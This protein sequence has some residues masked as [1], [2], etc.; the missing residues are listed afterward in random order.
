LIEFAERASY[1]GVKNRLNNFIQLPLPAGGNGAGA[2]P[3]GTQQNAGALGMGLQTASAITLLLTFL[4]YLTPLFGGYISDKRWGRMKTIWYGVWVGAVSHIILIVAAIPSVIK[5]GHALAPTIISILT[6]AVGSGLI[7]PNLLP[8]L[9]DQYPHKRDAVETR[10][11]GSRV[12]IVREASLERMTMFFYWAV[13]VGSFLSLG[14]SYCAKRI[15]F[16]LAFLIPGI[17]YF[18]MVP[19]L[20]ILAP[21]LKKETP[22]GVSVLAEALKVLKIAFAGNFI[23]RSRH[24][25]FWE[26]PKPSA[27]KVRGEDERLEAVTKKGNKKISWNDQFVEDVK[28]TWDAC[29]I[30]LFFVIYNINDVGIGGIQNSQAASMITNGVPNDLLD[31]FNP[32]TIIVFIPILD[33]IVYPLLRRW[34]INFRPVYRMFLGFILASLGSFAGAIIQWRIYET[35]PCGY[36]ATNC[37]VGTGVS[38][39]SVWF[40]II[41]YV[42][43]ASSECF[44]MT[45]AYEVAYTRAPDHMKGVVMALFLFTQSLSAAI[46]EACTSA[47]VDPYLIWPFVA[48][49]AAGIVSA[50]VFL[51]TYKDLHKVMEKERLE[52]EQQ[53]KIDYLNHIRESEGVDE[54][55]LEAIVSEKL[56]ME[57]EIIPVQALESSLTTKK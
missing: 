7:K 42:F 41:I 31:N 16:W 40:E 17:V 19:V 46:S 2:P 5:A 18:I 35:S 47:L 51:W 8:L 50:I 29:K 36:K 13:N 52:K 39:V 28:V 9:Y 43:Q 33:Y 44:A 20:I 25:D 21:H 37:D 23:K 11:D 38:P 24:G 4:A 1:Y 22:S 30:F 10:E 15:G 49:G 55:V 48:T 12:I 45:A 6:L 57:E 56:S 32:I 26:Y 27:I 54:N 14:T 3:S 53:L 34:N